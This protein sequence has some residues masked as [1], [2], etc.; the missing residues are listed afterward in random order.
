MM[1]IFFIKLIMNTFKRITQSVTERKHNITVTQY[2]IDECP[3]NLHR[4]ASQCNFFL[5]HINKETLRTKQYF[6]TPGK[7]STIKTKRDRTSTTMNHPPH[8][9]DSM[10]TGHQTRK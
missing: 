8:H 9:D 7:S 5:I 4:K 2:T 10:Q 6:I 3:L 1:Q